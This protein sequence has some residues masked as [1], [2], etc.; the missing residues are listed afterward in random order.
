MLYLAII[1]PIKCIVNHFTL[2]MR[3]HS[4]YIV[5]SISKSFDET[6]HVNK[7]FQIDLFCVALFQFNNNSNKIFKTYY[8]RN[9][10]LWTFGHQDVKI[11]TFMKKFNAIIWMDFF[12]RMLF[13]LIVFLELY[14]EVCRLY[15][16]IEYAN[17]TI[18]HWKWALFQ[19]KSYRL[20]TK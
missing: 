10:P 2:V 15:P 13:N 5:H 1:K 17:P 14:F 4:D 19:M 3:L 6:T 18:I 20:T 9:D 16:P 7:E 12:I 8:K 11:Q